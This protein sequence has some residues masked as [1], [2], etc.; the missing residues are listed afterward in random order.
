MTISTTTN[1]MEELNF[2]GIAIDMNEITAYLKYQMN[3][4]EICCQIL[5]DKIIEQAANI[6]NI[7]IS[8]EEI[9]L[10]A[11]EIRRHKHLEKASDTVAWLNEEMLSTDDWETAIEKDLL[12]QKL[13]REL[14]A[15]EAELYFNQ[16][17]LRFDK[18]LLYQLI[19]PY[20]KLAQELLYRIEEEE[21]SFYQAVHLYDIDEQRRNRCGY[22]GEVHR[23]DYPADMAAAIFRTPIPVGELTGPIK[24]AAGYHLFQIESYLPAELTPEIN[25]EIIDRL[26]QQWLRNELNY[27]IHNNGT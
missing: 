25:R 4:R 2:H 13:A 8:P 20:K 7:V 14:F 3:L 21:I 12:A 22:E 5:Y 15:R 9:N 26:F 16:N 11:E 19:V 6:R 18:F 17:R 24:S 1:Q 10:Q 23:Q 27:M